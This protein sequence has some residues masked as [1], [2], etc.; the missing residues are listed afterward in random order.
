MYPKPLINKT[1]GILETCQSKRLRLVVAESCTGGLLGGLLTAVPGSSSVFDRGFI[2]Y[3]NQAKV[4]ILGV[5]KEVLQ[6]Y[7]AVSKE[8]AFSMCA[9]ALNRSTGHIA[10]AITGIAGP[11][12]GTEDKP[13][14]TVFVAC[15]SRYGQRLS[16][17]AKLGDIGRD[18]I[19][20]RTLDV[21]LQ[22]ARKVVDA[23]PVVRKA[24]EKKAEETQA[25]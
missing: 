3:S 22:L 6:N 4:Q 7:G 16:T 15:M 1:K 25:S 10:I 23:A 8:T 2:T 17:Q 24:G 14:G 12:G 9:G 13:V 20:E 21:A 18:Q 11:D 19:R 5:K